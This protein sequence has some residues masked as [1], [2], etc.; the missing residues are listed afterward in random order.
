MGKSH[1]RG[2]LTYA[3]ALEIRLQDRSAMLNK[4]SILNFDL[5]CL[6]NYELKRRADCPPI[7]VDS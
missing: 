4:I 1:N 5:K 7:T 3:I 2:G 6:E